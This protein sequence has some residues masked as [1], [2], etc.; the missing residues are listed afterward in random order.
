MKILESY[1][2]IAKSMLVEHAWDR[3]FGEPLPTLD[4]VMNEASQDDEDYVHIGY[5]KYKDK[6]HV[7]DPSAPTFKKTDSGAFVP[8][9]DKEKGT[10]PED[11]R[12][13]PKGKGAEPSDFERDFGG[14]TG[15]D[16]DF[17]GEPPEGAREPDD[18]D[19]EEPK[20]EPADEPKEKQPYTNADGKFDKDAAN[21]EIGPASQ[22]GA[23]YNPFTKSLNDKEFD[24]YTKSREDGMSHTDAFRV[25]EH[26]SPEEQKKQL[27]KEI[28]ALQAQ[29]REANSANDPLTAKE[30]LKTAKDLAKK[31]SEISS[32]DKSG[33]IDPEL[34][35]YK[36]AA[37]QGMTPDQ[38]KSM[39]GES[40]NESITI[41]GKK[42]RPIKE[43]KQHKFK[44]IYDRT[45]MS[46]K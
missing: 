45:F 6:D 4:D 3:K 30:L 40:G 39:H 46:L 10:E 41:D 5:G 44:E 37:A 23:N 31:K 7:D 26:P 16:A 1:K 12:E 28:S 42:Y 2:K 20:D 21:N 9:K 33:E 19:D 14:D 13:E 22:W 18:V 35:L 29:A 8:F 38:Y 24:R 25:A 34:D 15:T 11:D 43:S 36:K 32:K 17:Q 27:D